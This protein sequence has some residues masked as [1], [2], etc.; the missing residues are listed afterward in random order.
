MLS[1]FPTKGQG[2]ELLQPAGF[3]SF[4]KLLSGNQGLVTGLTTCS[5]HQEACLSV[6]SGLAETLPLQKETPCEGWLKPSAC[7]RGELQ[8]LSAKSFEPSLFN[9]P[10]KQGGVRA[11]QTA[12]SSSFS[13]SAQNA[14][15]LWQKGLWSVLNMRLCRGAHSPL[16]ARTQNCSRIPCYCLKEDRDL[17]SLQLLEI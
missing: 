1:S 10:H 2:Y 11:S 5:S 12:L 3:I 13:R 4:Q 8:T 14:S 17:F 15:I 9:Y 16:P 6:S 7:T